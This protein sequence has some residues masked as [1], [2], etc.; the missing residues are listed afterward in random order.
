MVKS[1]NRSWIKQH[2]NDP[3]VKQ[4]QRDGYRSRAS[5]KLLEIVEKDRLI[6]SGMTVVDLGSAPG[7]WSQ[8]AARL[9]GH[10][11]RVHALDILPMDPIAGVDFIQGDFTEE[12]VFT[13]LIDLIGTRA[14]D[15][16]ISDIAPNLS[17]T[18]AVDQPAMIYLAE[19]GVDLAN[20]VLSKNGVFIAK[21][22]QGQGFDPF[23][24]QV[25]TLFNG[26]SI[27]KPDASRSRSRE[28]YLVAKGLK[29][30]T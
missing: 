21:L 17:G 5:Y 16:V 20:R 6:R 29:A 30:K 2:V 22:F 15:L 27:I 3:Y 24:Q 18:K 13:Q 7:G 12:A 1:K 26:V 9:V 19:L 14:V 23:V 11:G 28:V 4:S 8:V 25:R 10:E